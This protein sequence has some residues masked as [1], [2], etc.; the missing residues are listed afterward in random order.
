MKGKE[1]EV[2]IK[3]DADVRTWEERKSRITTG[4]ESGVDGV[5]V[6]KRT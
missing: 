2:W 3:A 4:L 6:E 5:L 1:K